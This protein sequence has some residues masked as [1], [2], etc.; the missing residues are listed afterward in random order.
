MQEQEEEELAMFANAGQS[1][2][3][4]ILKL[5]EPPPEKFPEEGYVCDIMLLIQQLCEGNNQAFKEFMQVQAYETPTGEVRSASKSH[6]L[7]RSA[8]EYLEVWEKNKT[9]HNIQYGVA[10]FNALSELVIGPCVD[11]QKRVGEDLKMETVNS[12]L[13]SEPI[14]APDADQARVDTRELKA[15]CVLLL[16]SML[17]GQ[18][19][20]ASKGARVQR[21][22]LKALEELKKDD[23]KNEVMKIYKVCS[24]PLQCAYSSV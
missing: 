14:E 1:N 13:R 18:S 23:I 3:K 20:G 6:D 24:S 17:E 15:S 21:R 22:I 2:A 16:H 8:V 12:I 5:T 9:A 19:K 7:V 10:V 4:E 11:N